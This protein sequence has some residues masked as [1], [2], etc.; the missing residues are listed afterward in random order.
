MPIIMIHKRGRNRPTVVCDVCHE[1]IIQHGNVLWDPD[2]PD[3]LYYVHKERCDRAVEQACAPAH[4][5]WE[6]LRSF[7]VFV[8]NNAKIPPK[9]LAKREARLKRFGI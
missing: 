1:P 4:L 8:S 9:D 6:E 3:R 7:L 2:R 5:F